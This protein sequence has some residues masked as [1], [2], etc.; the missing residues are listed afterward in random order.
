MKANL[1]QRKYLVNKK[2]YFKCFSF[3]NKGRQAYSK[4]Y[5]EKQRAQKNQNSFDKKNTGGGIFKLTIQLQ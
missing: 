2:E 4:M 3:K 1:N 5:M